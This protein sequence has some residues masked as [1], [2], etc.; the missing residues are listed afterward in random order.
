MRNAEGQVSIMQVSIEL[1]LYHG[2]RHT[3]HRLPFVAP[4]S[5]F[6]APGSLFVVAPFE[7]D[8]CR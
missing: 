8:E 5:L 4:G 3:C 1:A 7:H 6:V 2:S